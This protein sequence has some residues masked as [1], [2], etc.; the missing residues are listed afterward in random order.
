MPNQQDISSGDRT[1]FLQKFLRFSIFAFASSDLEERYQQ[2][3]TNSINAWTWFFCIHMLIATVNFAQHFY[4][5]PNAH[6]ALPHAW[7]LGLAQPA[8]CATMFMVMLFKSAFYRRHQRALNAAMVC[9]FLLTERYSRSAILWLRFV[10]AK[11]GE[12]S[13]VQNLKCFIAENVLIVWPEVVA[14]FPIGQLPDVVLTLV[15]VLSSIVS[16]RH[17]C[18]L[19]QLGEDLVTMSPSLLFPM[20]IA[21]T[22][23]SDLGGAS[24]GMVRFPAGQLS[25]SAAL[26]LW[27]VF[28]GALACVVVFASDF[29]KRRVFLETQEAR[30]GL[31]PMH[32]DAD[33]RWPYGGSILLQLAPP[34]IFAG[35]FA[36]CWS[37][38][39]VW[40]IALNFLV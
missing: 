22:F 39:L 15:L 36:L 10:V 6:A 1:P 32:E 25:C 29:S 7:F 12:Q 3:L 14:A 16:N 9:C 19:P 28:A 33:L 18:G 20:E 38:S 17:L 37:M 2:H 21:S 34:D 35:L 30:A 27:Q 31:G 4:L 5:Y 24:A 13:W 23:L 8:M 40:N 26:G 11:S